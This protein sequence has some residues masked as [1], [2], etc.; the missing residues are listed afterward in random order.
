L[1]NWARLTA[2]ISLQKV[3]W[4]VALVIHTSVKI[5][6]FSTIIQGWIWCCTWWACLTLASC[7]C[8]LSFPV[9]KI[10]HTLV[11]PWNFIAC[12][13][14]T[15]WSLTWWTVL[16]IATWSKVLGW[17]TGGACFWCN[18]LPSQ[19]IHACCIV[20]ILITS[21]MSNIGSFTWWTL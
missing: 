17:V 8:N 21:I 7:V 14:G 4:P 13:S 16:T 12:Y 15:I 1:T 2:S 5:S 18:W 6:F 9:T 3:S 10:S 20:W 19:L 11:I